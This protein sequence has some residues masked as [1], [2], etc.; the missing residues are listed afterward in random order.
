MSLG[1]NKFFIKGGAM[2][3]VI[4]A[5][6]ILASGIGTYTRNLI[7]EMQCISSIELHCVINKEHVNLIKNLGVSNYTIF[8]SRFF[9]PFEQIEYIF[10]LP[11]GDVLW[12]PHFNGPIMRMKWKFSARLAT[13]HD[14]F[15]FAFESNFSGLKK[16]YI[17][18]LMRA[19]ARVSNKILTV[20]EFSKTEIVKY[21]KV[22]PHK[23]VAIPLGVDPDFSNDGNI[24]RCDEKFILCVGNIKPHKNLKKAIR[25][26]S[27]IQH[28]IP[29]Y[30]LVLVGKS[31]GFYSP[32]LGIAE[33]LK[34][35]PSVIFTGFVSFEKLREY[36][37]NATVL[38]FPSLYEGF[39]LPVLEA[40]AFKIPVIASNRASIPE[41][42]RKAILYIDPESEDDISH[43][44]VNLINGKLKCD[45][46]GYEEILSEFTWKRCAL[47]TVTV[48]KQ[49]SR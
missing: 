44:I 39:G 26:F 7:R 8:R 16:K 10:K 43:T 12:I 3:V 40:M 20:S 5:R 28:L 34:D 9:S 22:Q 27:K 42:G 36:Y 33:I 15:P 37:A 18:F 21:L 30:K 49:I 23:I 25:A 45:I 31:E 6:M 14:M 13:I 17:H 48:L 41:V 19:T 38:L 47:E 29:E 35:N 4:D 46:L 32:E 1:I 2:L 11:K 24:S